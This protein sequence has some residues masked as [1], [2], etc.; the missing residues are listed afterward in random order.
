MGLLV[1]LDIKKKANIS[2]GPSYGN[3]ENLITNSFRI[4][5]QNIA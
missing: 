4:F 3:E 1:V 2:V 5:S